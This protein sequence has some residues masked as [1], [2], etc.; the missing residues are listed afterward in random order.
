[1][2]YDFD[3]LYR[4]ENYTNRN[5]INL[6]DKE[7]NNLN[8]IFLNNNFKSY[9]SLQMRK[10]KFKKV[11]SYNLPISIN[12]IKLN[13]VS[14]LIDTDKSNNKKEIFN[15]ED[16]DTNI[17]YNNDSSELY[18][19]SFEY[20][21]KY[22]FNLTIFF[23]VKEDFSNL[24]SNEDFYPSEYFRKNIIKFT[25]ISQ[26]DNQHFSSLK[27]KLINLIELKKQYEIKTGY[28]DLILE[29]KV[30]SIKL[31]NYYNIVVTNKENETENKIKMKHLKTKIKIKNK[32]YDGHYIY[33]IKD[34]KDEALCDTCCINLK[35]TIFLPCHHSCSCAKCSLNIIK[36]GN[37]CPICRE[38]IK[39]VIII[40]NINN[41]S[42]NCN[43]TL[44]K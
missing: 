29:F 8:E 19:L 33:G 2:G 18:F 36:E 25:D 44:S 28:Y 38:K 24:N 17:G 22:N 13:R 6:T 40:K 42:K 5:N 11:K 23:N 39:K 41:V 16:A 31:V 32:W 15:V 12:T 4:N 7:I 1:M 9:T 20:S 43:S 34:S 35:N 21:S 14:N 10:Q 26:G 30:N 3:G 37:K 27:H